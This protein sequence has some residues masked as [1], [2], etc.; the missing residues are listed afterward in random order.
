MDFY[1]HTCSNLKNIYGEKGMGYIV[2]KQLPKVLKE[3]KVEA[4]SG[5]ECYQRRRQPRSTMPAFLGFGACF[6]GS[7][8]DAR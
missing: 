5:Y 8:T 7:K 6:I 2:G 4:I 1:V 3:R